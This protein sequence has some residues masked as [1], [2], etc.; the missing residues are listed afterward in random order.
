MAQSYQ[1]IQ[2]QIQALQRQAEKLKSD[3]IAGVVSRIRAAIEHYGLTAEQL[4]FAGKGAPKVA[5]KK[6]R[7]KAS[8]KISQ[9]SDGN[10]NEWGGRG[11]RPHWLRDAL[12]SGKKLEE[13]SIGSAA[14]TK[15]PSAK[16]DV[17]PKRK[18]K[19]QYR[20]GSGN[21]WSGMGPRPRW[22]KEAIDGGASLE[23]FIA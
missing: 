16:S 11:P 18:A 13:F 12:A 1:Q 4:G 5:Q 19:L 22:L 17:A 20:D 10:G 21:S 6:G 9:Y 8:S 2:R 3:E 23:Q 15:S 14:A 7:S